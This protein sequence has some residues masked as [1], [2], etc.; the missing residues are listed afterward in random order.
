MSREQKVFVKALLGLVFWLV[1]AFLIVVKPAFGIVG[2]II[3]LICLVW[4]KIKHK[5]IRTFTIKK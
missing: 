5:P 4:N 3:G 1:V 2:A